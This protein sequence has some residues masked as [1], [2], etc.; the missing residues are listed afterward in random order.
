MPILKNIRIIF[1]KPKI[2]I[3]GLAIVIFIASL[4]TSYYP[5]FKKGY[6]VGI[7]SLNLLEARNYAIA[8]TYKYES[9]NGVFLSADKAVA[10]GKKLAISNP[11]TPIIYGQIFKLLGTEKR[12]LPLYISIILAAIFNVLIFLLITNLFNYTIGFFSAVTMVFMPV[13]II[14]TL[15]MGSYEF[16][17]IFFVLALFLFFDPKKLFKASLW[18]LACASVFFALAAL[19]RNAF[20]ISFAPFVLFDFYKNRSIKRGLVLILPFL[21]IF[22]S[23]LTSYSWLNVPN[24]YLADKN[25]QSFS[26]VGHVYDDPYSLY[27]D[28]NYINNLRSREEMNRVTTHFLSLWGYEVS[29]SDRLIAYKDSAQYYIEHFI[30]L[31]NY[32]GPLIIMF[33]FL[34]AYWLYKNKRDILWF[35]GVWLF[36]WLCGL[37]AFQ[38]GNWDHS[39]EI[40]FVVASLVGVGLYQILEILKTIPIRQS[41]IAVFLLVF[42][43]GHLIYSGKWN[44]FDAYR[45]SYFGAAFELAKKEQDLNSSGVIAV[46]AHSVFAYAFYYLTNHDVIYF[47]P[48]TIEE[49]IKDKKLK[50]AFGI[51]KVKSAFG[52][53]SDLSK[54]INTTLKI[55]VYPYDKNN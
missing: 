36:M 43:I 51:Y 45:S 26:L 54:Q 22:G 18:R 24:G 37:V 50:E 12:M 53:S 41:T 4:V 32:G 34:G 19:S 48:N 16:A 9:A 40:I 47:N 55:P 44:L 27:Y 31:T 15:F 33:M 25:D 20:L 2:I 1:M 3:G 49:L 8:G 28:S 52:Y 5:V 23:T 17:M 14:G 10:E 7:D 21:I 35:F 30:S 6:T 13:R 11:L 46:G 38:T 29:M 42:I 39:L